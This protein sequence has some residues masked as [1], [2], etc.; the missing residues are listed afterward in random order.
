MNWLQQAIRRGVSFAPPAYEP[1][2]LTDAKRWCNVD[3]DITAD[4]NLVRMVV[5]AARMRA[6]SL[7]GAAFIQRDAVLTMDDLPCDG[8][9]ITL[10][11]APLQYV[12]YLKY[13]DGSGVQ[14]TLSGSP[15]AFLVD[16]SSMPGR[17]APLYGASWPS[18]NRT[19]ANVRIGF[20]C[21]YAPGG[22]PDSDEA[23]YQ[24]NV[25]APIKIWMQQRVATYYQNREALDFQARNVAAM[26]RDFVDSL[27]DQYRV[28][29]GSA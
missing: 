1:V 8:C 2:T 23:A 20:R 14:Q 18:T 25:P 4:D 21:G 15:D 9:P 22:S 24:Y 16:T 6:E 7:T 27:L 3:D 13:L 10:P 12:S 11:L 28:D 29:F 19:M 26:P 17:I 5:V